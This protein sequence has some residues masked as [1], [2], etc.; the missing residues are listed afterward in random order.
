MIRRLLLILF[1]LATAFLLLVL[2]NKVLVG[3]QSLEAQLV[4][5]GPE[6]LLEIQFRDV[7]GQVIP[8]DAGRDLDVD[9]IINEAKRRLARGRDSVAPIALAESGIQVND[10]G[11]LVISLAD[12]EQRADEDDTRSNEQ[13]HADARTLLL[14]PAYRISNPPR[15]LFHINLGIDLR[16]GV[17]FI[18]R[19]Y[20]ANNEPQRATDVEV[21]ILRQR[22]DVRGLTEPQVSR[23]ANG[24][25]QVVI[26]GGTAAD[27]AATRRTL[28]TA[29]QLEFREVLAVLPANAL[30]DGRIIA[31]DNDRYAFGS[32]INYGLEDVIYPEQPE[33][34]G[35]RPQRFYHLGP[36]RVSGSDVARA[37]R[38]MREGNPAV[39][40]TFTTLGGSRNRAFTTEVF[41]RGRRHGT[42]EGTGQIAICFDQEV[43]SAPTVESPSGSNTQITGRFTQEEVD[44]LVEVVTAGALTR[45]PRILSQRVVGPSLGQQT[46][47]MASSAMLVSLA[48]ILLGM[49]AWYWWRLG[50]VAVASLVLCIGLIFVV[51]AL[52]GATLTLPGL[53]GLV[54]TVGMAVDAN[55]LIFERLREEMTV[56]SDLMSSIDRAY[57]R[58]F[59]TIIDANLTT[60]LTALVLYYFG[61]GPVQGFGLTLM[62]G[63]LTSVFAAVYVG[64]FLIT[65][66]HQNL[67][68]CTVRNFG[69]VRLPYMTWRRPAFALSAVVAVVGLASWM[70]GR[71]NINDHFDIE[72]TGGNQ[73]QVTFTQALDMDDV[74][75]ALAD[76]HGQDQEAHRVLDP[77]RLQALPYYRDFDLMGQRGSRQWTFRGPDEQIA[78]M[79]TERSALEEER[80]TR[81]READALQEEQPREAR[82]IR[83]GPIAELDAQINALSQRIEQRQQ[84]IEGMFRQAFVAQ[85]GASLIA[86]DGNEIISATWDESQ[87]RRL[88]MVLAVIDE[89]S[90]GAMAEVAERLSRRHEIES[91]DA[92][93]VDG[94]RPAIRFDVTFTTAPHG[95]AELQREDASVRRLLSFFGDRSDPLVRHQTQ[96]ASLFQARAVEQLATHGIAVDQPFPGSQSFSPQVAGQM[97]VAALIAVVISVVAILLYIA[98]RFEF[99]YGIGAI[100][101]LVHDVLL[102]VGLLAAFGVRIDLTVVAALL[103]IVGYSLNDT[104]V[105]FDRIRENILK[106]AKPLTET[107]DISIAQT[108]GRTILTTATTL[109]VV[110]LL[111]LFGG[112][113]VSSFSATLLIGLGIGTYSSVFIASPVLNAL[114]RGREVRSLVH[115]DD[116]EEDAEG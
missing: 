94:E 103:T 44:S 13:L 60:F 31:L 52:F 108:M 11:H 34:A 66:L 19:L 39:D 83:R 56:D 97:K 45:T 51:L 55:I 62:I 82:R 79:E 24:D 99:I 27:A 10:L 110:V 113:G 64:R 100:A 57:S 5:A 58:A 69:E 78:G 2:Q 1:V 98:A 49:M 9:G 116:D 115:R 42:G 91:V 90:A 61:T 75:S 15:H 59:I 92:A 17:E 46:I 81:R 21:Q 43:V 37:Q 22:L 33:I 84:E 68:T 104:I 35:D 54:L 74:R 16:G 105:V 87:P 112:E 95:I 38:G 36:Q 76:F 14:T 73:I 63:I 25:I 102:T 32:G 106:L 101:A 18:C 47:D 114:S 65:V 41:E 67:N 72:F 28:E 3:H 50:L 23:L 7:S 109:S 20:D 111:F 70:W 77:R 88:S 89:P 12:A 93:V 85:T 53:A 29:G 6:D 30:D 26:P 96:M 71:D 80:I 4:E 48:L 86:D 8:L 107:I 40:I